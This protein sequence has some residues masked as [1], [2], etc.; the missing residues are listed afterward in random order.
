MLWKKILPVFY[1]ILI[2]LF[3]LVWSSSFLVLSARQTLC[4]LTGMKW[5]GTK[6]PVSMGKNTPFHLL[7]KQKNTPLKKRKK[8]KIKAKKL[9]FILHVTDQGYVSGNFLPGRI[10]KKKSKKQNKI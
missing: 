9:A 10:K 1:F 3:V 8:G 5:Y 2:L 4:C 6:I 7:A